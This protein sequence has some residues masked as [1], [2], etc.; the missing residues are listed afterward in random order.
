MRSLPM[1]SEM[2]TG[3][4]MVINAAVNVSGRFIIGI[5]ADSADDEHQR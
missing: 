4:T 1:G 2:T 5:P 3:A